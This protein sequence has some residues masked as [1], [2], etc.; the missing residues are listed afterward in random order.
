MV[1]IRRYVAELGDVPVPSVFAPWKDERL[2][3]LKRYPGPVLE[4]PEN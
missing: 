2:L 3:R 1:S 4:V